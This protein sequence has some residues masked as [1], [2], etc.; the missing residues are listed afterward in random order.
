MMSNSSRMACLAGGKQAEA[1][2]SSRPWPASYILCTHSLEMLMDLWQSIP[3]LL[4][5]RHALDRHGD[6]GFRTAGQRACSGGPGSRWELT[7]SSNHCPATFCEPGIC[8][9]PVLQSQR[10]PLER[11]QVRQAVWGQKGLPNVEAEYASL[12]PTAVLRCKTLRE[13]TVNQAKAL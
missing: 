7:G 10:H 4:W 9:L 6:N 3:Q 11:T 8:G 5:R 1:P 13:W 2:A 12:L